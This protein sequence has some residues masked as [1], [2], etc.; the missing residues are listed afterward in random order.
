MRFDL[1]TRIF[2]FWVSIMDESPTVF[3]IH[4]NAFT[5]KKIMSFT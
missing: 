3:T 5:Y 2:T 4:D 1:E